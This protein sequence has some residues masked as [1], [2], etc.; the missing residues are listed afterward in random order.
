MI[1]TNSKYNTLLKTSE[2]FDMVHRTNKSKN[3]IEWNIIKEHDNFKSVILNRSIRLS[4]SYFYITFIYP[5]NILSILLSE[6]IG[7]S[8]EYPDDY[9]LLSNTTVSLDVEQD[10]E[11][12][13]Y[14]LYIDIEP[15]QK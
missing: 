5:L 4:D 10:N 13:K 15:I 8:H 9:N 7:H 2:K 1:I 11:D 14:I 6:D 12:D 3:F